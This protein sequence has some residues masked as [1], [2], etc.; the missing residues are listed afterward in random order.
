MT[1]TLERYHPDVAVFRCQN[2]LRWVVRSGSH[3]L[4]TVLG[5]F[6][7]YYEAMLF[8][9]KVLKLPPLVKV[10]DFSVQDYGIDDSDGFSS[11]V[12]M[13]ARHSLD[14]WERYEIGIGDNPV[15]ALDDT[16]ESIE[17]FNVDCT[18]LES[19][20]K[21]AYSAFTRKPEDLPSANQYVLDQW[22]ED[23]PYKDLEEAEE[24]IREHDYHYYIGIGWNLPSTSGDEV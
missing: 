13:L 11:K 2:P 22:K 4:S 8:Q 18:D 23:N 5:T 10:A 14:V 1:I 9:R 19:R 21:A 20:I 17:L 12:N 16:L 15:S 7:S 6:P 3:A 24:A